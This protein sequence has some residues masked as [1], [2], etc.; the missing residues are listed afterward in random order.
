MRSRTLRE[1]SVGLLIIVGISLFSGIALWLSGFKL[2]ERSYKFLI[3]FANA[4]GMKE[5]AMV[6]YRG[7]QVGRILSIKPNSNGV[8]VEVEINSSKLIIPRDIII[9]ANQSG[10][11]GETSID[12]KPKS[13]TQQVSDEIQ[14]LNPLAKNCQQPPVIICHQDRLQGIVGVSFDE[15]LRTTTEFSVLYSDPQ[16]FAHLNET[17]KNAGLA[18]GEIAKLSRELTLLSKTTRQELKG[19]SQIATSVTQAANQTSR[20]IGRTADQLSL[21]ANELTRLTQNINSVVNSNRNSITAT[22]VSLTD[23][24]KQLKNLLIGLN[25]TLDKVNATLDS[26]DTSKIMQNLEILT[27]NAATASANLRDLSATFNDPQ[28]IILLQKT[29][30]SAR[31]TFENTQKITSDLDELTGNP[32]FRQ[33]IIDLINGLSKLLSSTEQLEQQI[34]TA[35]ALEPIAEDLALKP[36][37]ISDKSLNNTQKP[38]LS[39]SKSQTKPNLPPTPE[40]NKSKKVVETK[41]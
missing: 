29:L 6:R 16:F 41:D 35:Q 4:N 36:A 27:T 7:F 28:T 11:I 9:E 15:L 21:T 5:G 34:A 8:T 20:Q 23:T 32:A 38:Q 37:K 26:S 17:A 24:S 31:V 12:I 18:A 25:P 1:G 13:I 30:D 10:F 14:S 39:L 33:N 3:Q 2:N 22:L 19:F 40:L